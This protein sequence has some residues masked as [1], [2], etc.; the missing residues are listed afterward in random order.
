MRDVAREAGC[1]VSTVSLALN[2][3]KR[4]PDSTRE[5]IVLVAK[6]VGYH[7]HPLVASWIKSRKSG[8][9]FAEKLPLAY[10]DRGLSSTFS[11]EYKTYEVFRKEADNNGFVLQ[12]FD[13]DDY[14]RNTSRLFQILSVRSITGV[15]IG[16]GLRGTSIDGV[17]WRDFSVVAVGDGPLY[18]SVH[19]VLEERESRI[20]SLLESCY[21]IDPRS[22]ALVISNTDRNIN[23]L[24]PLLSEIRRRFAC[25]SDVPIFLGDNPEKLKRWINTYQPSVVFGDDSRVLKSLDVKFVDIGRQD[26]Y[27]S[28]RRTDDLFAL[29]KAVL[30]LLAEFLSSNQRGLPNLRHSVHLNFGPEEEFSVCDQLTERD[31][32]V[33]A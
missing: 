7:I 2:G 13:I 16:P 3:D 12:R 5:R 22:V 18:P 10:I 4:I 20:R 14:S 28:P 1:H 19:R 25:G 29:G 31:S 23:L 24:S 27:H 26:L 17:E 21:L 11:D 33:S 9:C 32:V 6:R 8:K 15:I 30:D